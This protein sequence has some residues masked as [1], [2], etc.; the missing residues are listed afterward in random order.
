MCLCAIFLSYSCV[1]CILIDT[2]MYEGLD[3][4]PGIH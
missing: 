1:T 2:Y 4:G 3:G